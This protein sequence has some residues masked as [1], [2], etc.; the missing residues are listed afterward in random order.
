[1]FL[2]QLFQVFDLRQI[3][4]RPIACNRELP[5]LV[6]QIFAQIAKCL[7]RVPHRAEGLEMLVRRF[8]FQTRQF[9]A[10]GVVLAEAGDGDFVFFN[11]TA[12]KVRI[13]PQL[14]NFVHVPVAAVE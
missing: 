5:Y 14:P 12:Q 3:F 7:A 9:A 11:A 1:M 4:R 10:C 13:E 2:E 6:R 8:R